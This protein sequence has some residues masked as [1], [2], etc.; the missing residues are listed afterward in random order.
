[1]DPV[2]VGVG[3]LIVRDGLLLMQQRTGSHG[4]G[5]WSVPGGH[6]EHGETPQQ[7]A[8]R[9]TKEELN[10]TIESARLVA[11]TSDLFPE[12][13]K[14]YITLWL[15]AENIGDEEICINERECSAYG[16]FPLDALPSPLFVPLQNLLNGKSLILFDLTSLT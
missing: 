11:V 15:R 16:W 12:E 4:D 2:R 14:H 9:E 7:T 1:M 13:Q 5:T 8:V 6:I 3:V 10:L